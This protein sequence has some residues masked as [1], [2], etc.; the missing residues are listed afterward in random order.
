MDI[1]E[2]EE[3]A[4]IFLTSAALRAWLRLLPSAASMQVFKDLGAGLCFLPDAGSYPRRHQ[5]S[6]PP[7]YDTGPEWVGLR[8]RLRR[9]S[10][11]VRPPWAW[12]GRSW[13]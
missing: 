1:D 10:C 13:L 8:G 11:G 4:P 6:L 3:L 2:Q 5:W 7:K 12:C 9:T